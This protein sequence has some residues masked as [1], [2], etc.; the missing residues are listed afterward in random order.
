MDICTNCGHVEIEDKCEVQGCTSE[1]KYEGWYRSR[2]CAGISTGLIQRRRVCD[3]HTSLL[4]GGRQPEE[5]EPGS[6][7]DRVS[8]MVEGDKLVNGISV[9][10]GAKS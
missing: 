6:I 10:K 4:I 1:A 7:A 3:K 8:K 9:R 2:D 5:Y